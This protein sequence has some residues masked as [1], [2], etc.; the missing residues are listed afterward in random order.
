MLS[1]TTSRRSGRRL[2]AGFAVSSSER[3]PSDITSAP[4]LLWFADGSW[5][6]E[7]NFL[8]GPK[9]SEALLLNCAL[10]YG[11]I[12][13]LRGSYCLMINVVSKEE[14]Q[15][16][17]IYLLTILLRLDCLCHTQHPTNG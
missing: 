3:P 13:W 9:F 10:M 8:S 12:L 6:I 15:C 1:S 2:V 16:E 17:T 11:R 7:S 14:C 4:R 5:L